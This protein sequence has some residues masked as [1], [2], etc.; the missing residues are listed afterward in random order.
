MIFNE[1][2]IDRN[3]AELAKSYDCIRGANV[4]LARITPDF[5]DGLKPVQRR[6]LYIM[7]L[8]DKG[9]TFRKVATIDGEVIG[10]V[11]PHGPSS[12][13]DALVGVTQW[14]NNSIPLIEGSGNFGGPAGDPAGADRYI[15]AR[16]SDYAQACFFE[17][18][19]DSVVDMTLAFDEETME[20]LYLPAKY[21][22]VLLNGCIGIGYGASSNIPCYN[23]REVVEA[24]IMLMVDPNANIILIPDSPTG[25]D[26]IENDFGKLCDRGNGV[27]S[28]RCTYEIDDKN[29]QIIITSLPYQVPVNV[30]R[31]RIADIKERGGLSELVNMND[32]TGA[33]V[34]LRLVIRDDVNPY[35]FMKK[36]IKEVGGLEKSYPVILL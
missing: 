19:N 11:H 33:N 14:W 8:K 7:Y 30:I 25:A 3:I 16:L 21:P 15:K 9:K 24:V 34:D 18:W 31:E 28:M 36:L 32:M 13:Y 6:T 10:R 29:N 1:K 27:Y 26:I 4:N 17:D 20:P 5:I 2:F 22:N 35:K 23:F 12:V